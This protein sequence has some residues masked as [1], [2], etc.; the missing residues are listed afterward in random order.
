LRSASDNG[1]VRTFTALGTFVAVVALL[2]AACGGGAS[3]PKVASLGTTTSTTASHAAASAGGPASGAGTGS[4]SALVKHAVK[5]AQCMRGHGEAGFP[6]PDSAGSFSIA[7][8]ASLDRSSPRFQSAAKDCQALRPVPSAQA[9]T[10]DNTALLKFSTCMRSHGELNFPDFDLGSGSAARVAQ[11][12]LKTI[13]PLSPK[14]QA[15]FQ[16]CRPLLPPVI[17]S[18]LGS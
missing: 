18:A 1:T 4:S 5:Y 8:L 16:A 13:D 9:L 12:Y 11:Q 3:A 7:G 10:Q 6:D 17:G 14:F 15:A 2:A